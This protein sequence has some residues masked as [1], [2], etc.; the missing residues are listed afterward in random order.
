[1][2]QGGLPPPKGS[3]PRSEELQKAHLTTSGAPLPGPLHL[4]GGK[5]RGSSEVC[6]QGRR[7]VSRLAEKAKRRRPAKSREG[8]LARPRLP[9]PPPAPGSGESSAAAPSTAGAKGIRAPNACALAAAAAAVASARVWRGAELPPPAATEKP[10]RVRGG[11]EARRPPPPGSSSR[12][13][14]P[15][16]LTPAPAVRTRPPVT[17]P[18]PAAVTEPPRLRSVGRRRAAAPQSESPGQAPAH[19]SLGAGEAAAPGA[20]ERL[21]LGRAEVGSVCVLAGRGPPCGPPRRRLRSL[22]AA[23]SG[24]GGCGRGDASTRCGAAARSSAPA[25]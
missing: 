20:Q 21:R 22:A 24:G 3:L 18:R 1:M 10:R 12:S 8:G 7:A 9:T 4:G 14:P 15:S 2:L 16:Q 6:Q 13:P 19:S 25:S 17:P 5:I 23:C 11:G